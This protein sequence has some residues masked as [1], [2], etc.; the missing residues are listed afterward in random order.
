MRA[1]QNNFIR[2]Q[3]RLNSAISSLTTLYRSGKASFSEIEERKQ[4]LYAA[5]NDYLRAAQEYERLGGRVVDHALIRRARETYNSFHGQH[6]QASDLLHAP[7]VSE[8]LPDPIGDRR[9]FTD[10]NGRLR[11]QTY[12]ESVR[13]VTRDAFKF[14]WSGVDALISAGKRIIDDPRL[15]QAIENSV[16]GLL[17]ARQISPDNVAIQTPMISELVSQYEARASQVLTERLRVMPGFNWTAAPGAAVVAGTAVIDGNA[18]SSPNAAN[19]AAEAKRQN[20]LRTLGI[21]PT[22][23][24]PKLIDVQEKIA[25]LTNNPPEWKRFLASAGLSEAEGKELFAFAQ[26]NSKA[27]EDMIKY[28]QWIAA[29]KRHREGDG[30]KEFRQKTK[31]FQDLRHSNAMTSKAMESKSS[32]LIHIPAVV[33]GIAASEA[34]VAALPGLLDAKGASAPGVAP[35]MGSAVEAA[36]TGAYETAPVGVAAS[37]K[38]AAQTVIA[39]ANTATIAG[40]PLAAH[41]T[42]LKAAVDAS[43]TALGTGVAPVDRRGVTVTTAITHMA[44]AVYHMRAADAKSIADAAFQAASQ[45]KAAITQAIRAELNAQAPGTT[46]IV[47]ERQVQK[48]AE[49]AAFGLALDAGASAAR[50]VL[51]TVQQDAIQKLTE[52]A[53]RAMPTVPPTQIASLV[54]KIVRELSAVYPRVVDD[55]AVGTALEAAVSGADAADPAYTEVISVA[56]EAYSNLRSKVDKAASDAAAKESKDLG[57]NINVNVAKAVGLAGVPDAK[58]TGAVQ[59]AVLRVDYS[60]RIVGAAAM[61]AATTAALLSA[62]EE[63]DV[64]NRI[65]DVTIQGVATQVADHYR[66]NGSIDSATFMA[67]GRVNALNPTFLPA[68]RGKVGLAVETNSKIQQGLEV[69]RAAA[70]GVADP[71]EA[72][73]ASAM[74]SVAQGTGLSKEMSIE[75]GRRIARD[76]A[77][78]PQKNID[79]K[80][81]GE[82]IEQYQGE[83]NAGVN[84][85]QHFK[86]STVQKNTLTKM[87][88]AFSN[89]TDPAAAATS[90]AAAATQVSPNAENAEVVATL[91]ARGLGARPNTELDLADVG[92]AAAAARVGAQAAATKTDKLGIA[93]ATAAAAAAAA[94]AFTAAQAAQAAQVVGPPLDPAAIPPLQRAWGVAFRADAAAQAA[95]VGAAPGSPPALAAAAAA[96]TLVGAAAALLAAAPDGPLNG[97]FI[98]AAAAALVAQTAAVVAAAAAPGV[99][100]EAKAAAEAVAELGG[101]ANSR[102]TAIAS[103]LTVT[104]IKAGCSVDDAKRLAVTVAAPEV[105]ALGRPGIIETL[106]REMD[107]L[108]LPGSTQ[109]ALQTTVYGALGIADGMA[110]NAAVVPGTMMGQRVE[111]IIRAAAHATGATADEI[112]VAIDAAKDELP[113]ATDVAV[114]LLPEKADAVAAFAAASLSKAGKKDAAFAVSTALSFALTRAPAVKADHASR[115]AGASQVTEEERELGVRSKEERDKRVRVDQLHDEAT[116]LAARDA[117]LAARQAMI[118]ADPAPPD[119]NPLLKKGNK[120]DTARA[121]YWQVSYFDYEKGEVKTSLG[122]DSEPEFKALAQELKDLKDFGNAMTLKNAIVVYNK[123]RDP[124]DQIDLIRDVT[125]T[126]GGGIRVTLKHAD[127]GDLK[128]LLAEWVKQSRAVQRSTKELTP[129]IPSLRANPGG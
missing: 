111:S 56:V 90:V 80:R 93:A 6:P 108:T 62:N 24:N 50:G 59:S 38:T 74:A 48:M 53:T 87:A 71:E 107:R 68:L 9:I 54:Q 14:H 27:Q 120:L 112:K 17:V 4:E 82:L 42:E 49:A 66:D 16:G 105:V 91:A 30:G 104:A 57:L 103:A 86:F 33:A 79:E 3:T 124:A 98:A 2:E 1:A 125:D 39:T 77:K 25:V 96:N 7:E 23:T 113:D 78:K 106:Q 75:I 95:A 52:A 51:H 101:A 85:A 117:A 69:G 122:D 58:A 45:G 72:A 19:P 63:L 110:A 73:M 70:A 61:A 121:D 12:G 15:L 81:V 40:A 28:P 35:K 109:A 99:T 123:T 32:H 89:K 26:A 5:Q 11:A 114:D 8:S 22:L 64:A 100:P 92:H 47:R 43:L 21:D 97:A 83:M 18:T 76:T 37:A 13:E 119:E 128:E 126:Q 60:D 115:A 55:K 46:A 20:M 102:Q 118:K 44:T 127:K 34:A 65:N 129:V 41:A 31:N 29:V 10:E 116:L 67:L 84:L 36:I 94:A 88:V